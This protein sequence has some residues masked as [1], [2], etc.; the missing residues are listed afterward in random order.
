[1]GSMNQGQTGALWHPLSSSPE[2]VA[3]GHL[4]LTSTAIQMVFGCT[5]AITI[6]DTMCLIKEGFADTAG[7]IGKSLIFKKSSPRWYIKKVDL[8][9]VGIVG[10]LFTKL[11]FVCSLL[12]EVLNCLT[13]NFLNFAFSISLAL[14]LAEVDKTTVG[15][16]TA[17]LA[18]HTRGV[19][20][21]YANN[22][23]LACDLKVDG[24]AGRKTQ[25]S[26]LLLKDWRLTNANSL[27]G[28]NCLY[29]LLIQSLICRKHMNCRKSRIV[30]WA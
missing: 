3:L 4:L 30:I 16:L 10:G 19:G 20:S 12:Q 15:S 22:D 5:V 1:M 24:I 13:Y 26:W 11:H 29:Q 6:M 27:S 7:R 25:F 8:T 18:A 17:D 23:G 9:D 28:S 21:G 14:A 2:Q